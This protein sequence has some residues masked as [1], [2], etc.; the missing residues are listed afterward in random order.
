MAYRVIEPPYQPEQLS[1]YLSRE[2]RRIEVALSQDKGFSNG[3]MWTTGR[4][5]PDGVIAAPVGSLFSRIDGGTGTSLY[6]KETGTGVTGW[7]AK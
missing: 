3:V 2:L 1:E 5:S 4:G 6:V 7:V